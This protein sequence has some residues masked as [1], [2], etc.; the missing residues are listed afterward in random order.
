LLLTMKPDDPQRRA[1]LQRIKR[2]VDS[3]LAGVV[4]AGAASENAVGS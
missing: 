4:D 2:W 3:A 1:G